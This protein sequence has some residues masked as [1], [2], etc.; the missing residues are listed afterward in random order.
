MARSEAIDSAGSQFFIV[1]Q[2][3]HFLDGKY[4]AFGKII[5]CELCVEFGK[6]DLGYDALDNIANLSTGGGSVP[7]DIFAATIDTTVIVDRPNISTEPDRN[8]SVLKKL[9]VGTKKG[10]EVYYNNVHKTK[11]DIPYRWLLIEDHNQD[12]L[13]VTLELSLIHI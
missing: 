11:F 1:H 5:S 12:Y 10:T 9:E 7:E 6:P 3:S 8:Y 2:D 13:H 4:T